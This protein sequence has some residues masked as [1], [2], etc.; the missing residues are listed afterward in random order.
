LGS[1]DPDSK[2]RLRRRSVNSSML[3]LTTSLGRDCRARQ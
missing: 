3:R 2:I 1:A